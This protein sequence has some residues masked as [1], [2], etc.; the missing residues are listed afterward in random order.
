MGHDAA[1]LESTQ[2]VGGDSEQPLLVVGITHSQT[3]LVL[4]GRLSALRR[5]GFRVVLISSPGTL[6]DQIASAEGVESIPIPM[7]RGIAPFSDVVS[8]FR[9]WTTLRRLRPDIAEFSTP[10]AGLL[11][12]LASRFSGV[13]VRIYLLRGL[14]LETASGVTRRLLHFTERVAAA[15]CQVVVCN[16]ESLRRQA[17]RLGLADEA[18]LRLVGDG[19]SNGV[20]VDRFHPG[21]DQVRISF[22]ISRDAPVIGFVGR[23]TRDKGIPELI[24]AFEAL[25]V[26]LPNAWL[27]LVGWFDNSEDALSAAQRAR[28]ERDPRIICTGYVSD[29]SPWYRAMDVMVLPTRREGFPNVAL[30][31]AASGIPVI[32]TVAT[33]ARDAVLPERTGLLI[34]PGDSDAIRLAVCSL[35]DDPDRRKAMGTAGRAWVKDRFESARVH[36]LATALYSALLNAAE[37][38]R[39]TVLAKDAVAAAD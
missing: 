23:L 13:P 38:R 6:L 14:R 5:A 21:P 22:G 36:R 28:I 8:F 12:S 7:K 18:K 24:E 31:A 15:C 33:G 9:L 1:H 26:Q 39:A 11:G 32:S 34:P 27:F 2:A 35:L 3:C 20:D 37:P 16:S 17:R 19:S 25:R 30:E 29:T 4:R 10:K